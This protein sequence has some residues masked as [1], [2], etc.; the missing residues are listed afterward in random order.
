MRPALYYGEATLDAF[1]N[2]SSGTSISGADAINGLSDM[3]VSGNLDVTCARSADGHLTA[4]SA[5][6]DAGAT[7]GAPVDD[8]DGERRDARPDIGPDEV[9]R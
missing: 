4:A 2:Y 7:T 9:V 8:M 5:C 3:T 1:S 6:I